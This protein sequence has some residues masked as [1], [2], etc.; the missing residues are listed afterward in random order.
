MIA[1]RADFVRISDPRKGTRVAGNGERSLAVFID[2]ENLAL[3]LRSRD[4]FQIGRVLERL[5]EKGKILFKRAYADWSRFA[6]YTSQL[7][8]AAIEL[9]EI[10]KSLLLTA[11]DQPMHYKLQSRQTPTPASCYVSD[12]QGLAFELYFDGGTERKLQVRSLAKRNCIVHAHWDVTVKRMS[13]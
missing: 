1:I 7:H 11:Q 2:F 8:E 12:D 5:V 9:V 13:N 10:P 3:G 4:R 6:N